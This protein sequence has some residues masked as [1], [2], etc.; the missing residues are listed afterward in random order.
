[1]Q[2]ELLADLGPVRRLCRILLN[3]LSL[4]KA[5]INQSWKSSRNRDLREKV[6]QPFVE[7]R[8]MERER[9]RVT[10]LR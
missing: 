5:A 2:L 10:D 8:R 4:L 6:M 7:R 3:V 9:S 1:M